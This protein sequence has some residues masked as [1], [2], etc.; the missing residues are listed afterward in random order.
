MT[1]YQQLR[2]FLEDM[3]QGAQESLPVIIEDPELTPVI[4]RA[5]IKDLKRLQ[6]LLQKYQP[7]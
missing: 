2:R 3:T 4:L 7:L 6:R 5:L 1:E